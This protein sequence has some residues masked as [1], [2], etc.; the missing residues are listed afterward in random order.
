MTIQE[1]L[2]KAINE[3][4][5]CNIQ[6]PIL[7]ARILLAFVLDK[8]KE[9]L[10]INENEN[11]SNDEQVVFEEAIYRLIQGEPLQHI[12]G[13]Q[14]FM[15]LK[16]IVNKDVLIPRPDTEI[17]VEEVVDILNNIENPSVLDLCTGSGAI[18]I[19]IAKYV[20]N[21][22][23]LGTDISQKAVD[24]AIQNATKIMKDDNLTAPSRIQFFQ[25]DLF[26]NIEGKFDLIVSNPPYIEREEI[27]SLDEEV[28]K[29]PVMALD[30]GEDGL[31]F[32]KRIILEA[33]RYIKPEGYLCL[34][35]GYNQKDKV[36][37]LIEDSG[38]YY[39]IYLKKD[40]AGNDRV[41]ICRSQE[42]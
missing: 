11:L 9:Y 33:Y 2:N 21:A 32:Y 1:I 26:N 30:G 17:L 12:T 23:V 36:I 15:K 16:F 29:E 3:L 42:K 41:V 18:A 7:K 37:K 6:E 39:K 28:Q 8:S 14:E 20:K 5:E 35:I 34:E 25:S 13:M 22:Y 38:K 10:V 31:E 27:K 40:L 19:S 4:K 24:I